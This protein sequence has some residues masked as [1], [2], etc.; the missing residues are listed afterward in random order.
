MHTIVSLFFA[1][2]N[3]MIQLPFLSYP[4]NIPE[5]SEMVYDMSKDR[6]GDAIGVLA[7]L[8]YAIKL[9]PKLKLSI[10]YCPSNHD[11]YSWFSGINLFDWSIWQPYKV[12]QSLPPGKFIFNSTDS[13]A[14]SIWNT[15]KNLNLQPKLR[16]P[17]HIDVSHNDFNVSMHII[18][19]VGVR[20]KSYVSRRALS[21]EKYENIGRYLCHNKVTVTRLGAAYD[22]VR[23]F[24]SCVNDFTSQNLSLH[25][26]FINLA[27]SDLFMGGDSGLTH[28]AAAL[29]IPIIVEVDTVSKAA[30][31]L[32]GIPPELLVEIPYNCSYETHL[33]FLQNHPLLKYKLEQLIS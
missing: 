8:E 22:R 13:G 21:M 32:A 26:T 11:E 4:L 18:N 24:D 28:A 27:K 29:G 5:D 3:K 9:N 31:G 30:L 16:V 23:D 19:A 12:Y 20:N 1:T 17:A 15:L 6:I 10:L 25:N 2:K 33:L 7:I 14:F